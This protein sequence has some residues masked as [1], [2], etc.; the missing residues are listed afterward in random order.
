MMNMIMLRNRFPSP[1][2]SQSESKSM[3]D[4]AAAINAMNWDTEEGDQTVRRVGNNH[5]KKY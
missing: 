3:I 4:Q 5:R 2:E 1:R